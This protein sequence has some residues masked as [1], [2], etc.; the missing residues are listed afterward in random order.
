MKCPHCQTELPDDASF[1]MI[2]GKTMRS[3]LVMVVGEPGIGKTALTQQ[4]ATYVTMRGGS[5]LVGY[6]Y[7]E[8]SLSLPYLAFVEAM[9]T[10]VLNR[11]EADLRFIPFLN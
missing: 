10:Y 5:T 4:L 1:C 7:E 3:C 8:G 9:R 6:C 2:C 11:D